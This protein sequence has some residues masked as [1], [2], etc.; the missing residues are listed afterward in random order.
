MYKVGD[1]VEIHAKNTAHAMPDSPVLNLE[2]SIAEIKSVNW[3]MDGRSCLY[4]LHIID[5]HV[6]KIELYEPYQQDMAWKDDHLIPVV[7]Y[8]IQTDDMINV[9]SVG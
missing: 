7:E 1:I 6:R 5:P 3:S 2:G 9:F 4:N 8:D